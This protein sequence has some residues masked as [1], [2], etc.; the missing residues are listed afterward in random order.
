MAFLS[1]LPTGP[2]LAIGHDDG[3]IGRSGR[4]GHH[5]NADRL[6]PFFVGDADG[7]AFM[8]AHHLGNDR[9]HLAAKD[10]EAS[11]DNHVLLAVD[12]LGVAC[13]VHHADVP[14]AEI[15]VGGD[16]LRGLVRPVSVAGHHL[17]TLGA[18]LA[19]F[20][21]R[22][23]LALVVADRDVGR[24]HGEA[25]RAGELVGVGGVAGQRRRRLRQAVAFRQRAA[26]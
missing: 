8:D 20:A 17:R 10:V 4:I 24:G 16:H 19:G 9:L 1:N 25:D 26:G 22:H 14:G 11:G 7:G 18:D 5:Q 15:A 13:R 12:D 23:F 3:G 2:R 21:E 6:A